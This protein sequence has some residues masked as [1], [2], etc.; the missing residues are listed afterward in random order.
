[1]LL[2]SIWLSSLLSRFLYRHPKLFEHL[3]IALP[4]VWLSLSFTEAIMDIVYL[5]GMLLFFGLMAAM[6]IGCAR[7]GGAK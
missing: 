3:D 2:Q 7:L 5:A 4:I 6:A 1:M